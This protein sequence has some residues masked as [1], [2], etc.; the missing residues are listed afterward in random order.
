[1]LLAVMWL[2]DGPLTERVVDYAKRV[3]IGRLARVDR[4]GESQARQHH[5]AHVQQLKAACLDIS[6]RPGSYSLQ[7]E[8]QLVQFAKAQ[9]CAFNIEVL[10]EQAKSKAAIGCWHV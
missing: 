7:P 3:S 2:P 9:H 1:M 10:Q 4:T 8:P 6:K 5:Q